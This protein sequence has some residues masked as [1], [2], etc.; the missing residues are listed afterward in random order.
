MLVRQDT[1]IIANTLELDGLRFE[2]RL[3]VIFSNTVLPGESTVRGRGS[4]QCC[5]TRPQ[6]RLP[7]QISVPQEYKGAVFGKLKGNTQV[8]LRLGSL[9]RERERA[10]VVQG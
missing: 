1:H 9:E 2:G 5:L 8:C 10:N 7:T 6:R 3:D 4:P